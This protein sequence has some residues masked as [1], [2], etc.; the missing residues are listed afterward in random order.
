MNKYKSQNMSNWTFNG[1]IN[2]CRIIMAFISC[3]MK[4]GHIL[5]KF[6]VVILVLKAVEDFGL[7]IIFIPL[8]LINSMRKNTVLQFLKC[9][10]S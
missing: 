8:F 2:F 7:G 10:L 6:V 1:G 3:F 4:N 9:L 5:K